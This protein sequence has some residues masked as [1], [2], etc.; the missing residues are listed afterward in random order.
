MRANISPKVIRRLLA[1]DGYLDLQM[2]EHALETLDSIDDAGLYEA[3]RLYL[4]GCA[5]MMQEKFEDA[6]A[7]LE[8]AA[9]MMP[10]PLR[11]LAWARLSQCY[12]EV[13]SVH[14]A[15]IAGSL[16]GD[17]DEEASFQVVLPQVA[18]SLEV[19]EQI[20]LF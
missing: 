19:R 20:E 18:L 1:A 10:P 17:A 12:R 13:G 7:P 4:T 9:R 2:P 14:L 16:A 6:V 11:R 3:P 15:E 5:L 8:Q